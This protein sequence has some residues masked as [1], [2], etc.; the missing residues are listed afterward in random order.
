[1]RLPQSHRLLP[2]ALAAVLGACAGVAVVTTAAAN[3]ADGSTTLERPANDR[4]AQRGADA[5]VLGTVPGLTGAAA[6]PAAG[7]AATRFRS[8]ATDRG[9][10]MRAAAGTDTDRAG[11]AALAED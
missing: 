7:A 6:A 9:R 10:Q 8:M 3:P 4:S 5:P 1:M 11:R 2:A